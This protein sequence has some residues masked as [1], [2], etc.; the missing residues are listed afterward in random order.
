MNCD[1]YLKN[2]EK[3]ELINVLKMEFDIEEKIIPTETRKGLL[4]D[5][6]KYLLFHLPCKVRYVPLVE[7][8][9]DQFY[10]DRSEVLLKCKVE[11]IEKIVPII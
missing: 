10:P 9:L 3:I 8:M 5:S 7:Q 2:G 4:L 11:D 1:I 6:G